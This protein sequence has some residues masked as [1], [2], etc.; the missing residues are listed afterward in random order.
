MICLLNESVIAKAEKR[1]YDFLPHEPET[2]TTTLFIIGMAA[3]YLWRMF[4]ITPRTS[5]LYSYVTFI[6]N[7]PFYSALNWPS[8]DN[9][10]GY[11]VLSSLLYYLGN[12]YVALRGISYICAV[13]NLILV[14]RIC[15]RYYS[16][17][18]PL[19]A[20]V[21]YASMQ[22]V[23][24][25]SV[26]GRGYTLATFCFL[27][28]F[29]VACDICR[30]GED[31]KYRYAAFVICSVYGMY[32]IPGSINWVVP[33][34]LSAIMFL[35][36]NGFRSRAVYSSDG[37]NVYFRKLNKVFGAVA[38]IIF[39]TTFLY[40]LLWLSIG[41]NE[42]VEDVNSQYYG[43]SN[44][45]VLIRNPVKAL[46]MGIS[47]MAEHRTGRSVETDLFKTEFLLW[48][49][50]LFNYML[51]GMWVLIALFLVIGIIIMITECIR[52]FEYS[53]TSLNL[54]VVINILYIVII[55][56]ST[57]NLPNLKGFGYG[58]FLETLCICSCLEK[59]INILIRAYNMWKDTGRIGPG[60]DHREN[61]SVR[62]IAHWYDGIF[63]YFPV[64]LVFI[65]FFFRIHSEDFNAQLGSRENI[66]FDTMY[67]ANIANRSNPTVLDCDQDYLLQF[68]WGIKCNKIDVT[69]SDCVILDRKMTIPGYSGQDVWKFYQN[70]N[71]I[72]WDYL[73]SMHIEYQNDNF[74]LYTRKRR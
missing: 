67:I 52:H 2:M 10:V 25:Y 65:L 49:K 9:H 57:R 30:S 61:E 40:T 51:P 55:L 29:Y 43:V 28:S 39:S 33:L 24:D 13:S 66:L 60:T 56:F 8:E 63:V 64:F 26:Q 53:R 27:L 12:S 34:C 71:S 48:I 23:N 18:L 14:Y 32:T 16:H 17:A 31:L 73:D 6:S 72:D 20:M 1:I 44:G 19:V 11:S 4:A 5:E 41:S 15:K 35:F 22:V 74:I 36:I 58:S 59:L 54:I 3:Y 70:Y 62:V 42:L 46:G 37:E 45:T 47:Y 68:E 69:D 7:G 38:I 21:L 50:D